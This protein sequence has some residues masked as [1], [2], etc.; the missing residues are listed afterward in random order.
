MILC[1]GIKHKNLQAAVGKLDLISKA[2]TS[3][4]QANVTTLVSSFPTNCT[5]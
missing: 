5:L 2:M 4:L 1:K 3:S